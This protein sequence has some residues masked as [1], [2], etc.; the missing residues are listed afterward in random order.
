MK[1]ERKITEKVKLDGLGT[2]ILECDGE[3]VPQNVLCGGL[4]AMGAPAEEIERLAALIKQ[5]RDGTDAW[6]RTVCV[7]H[8]YHEDVKCSKCETNQAV[9]AIGDV[10]ATAPVT[11]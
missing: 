9:T 3:G 11:Q 8:G 7:E 10:L 5:R 6:R 4:P 2:V 1:I